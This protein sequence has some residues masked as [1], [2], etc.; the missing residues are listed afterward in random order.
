MLLPVV[1]QGRPPARE[2]CPTNDR[3]ALRTGCP[4]SGSRCRDRHAHS[5]PALA[6]CCSRPCRTNDAWRTAPSPGR[7]EVADAGGRPDRASDRGGALWLRVRPGQLRAGHHR[8]ATGLPR[9]RRLRRDAGQRRGRATARHRAEPA[10]AG[11][12]AVRRIARHPHARRP[13]PRPRRPAAGQEGARR[14]RHHDRRSRADGAHP[15]AWRTRP[16]HHPGTISRARRAG[17]ST[18]PARA[19]STPPTCTPSC[20]TAA[21]PNSS[22]PA[23]PPRCA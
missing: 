5:G 18:S 12:V 19:R 13:P 1:G 11:G 16:R 3:T 4:D 6:G 8:H 17:R 10:P 20:R 7:L 14:R 22:S 23:S 15:G 9:A 21:S 2:N